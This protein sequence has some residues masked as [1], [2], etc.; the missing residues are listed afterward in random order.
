M[1]LI[2]LRSKRSGCTTVSSSNQMLADILQYLNHDFC[3][4]PYLYNQET[5]GVWLKGM[6]I[7]F[8][9]LL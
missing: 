2:I 6:I 7:S 9:Q 5:P 8:M 4:S 1:S 3:G